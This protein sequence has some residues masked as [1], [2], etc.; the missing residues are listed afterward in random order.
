MQLRD[1]SPADFET[2]WKIDQEC[3]PPGIAYSRLELMHYLRRRG[4]FA[5][6]AEQDAG[7]NVR[8]AGFL[9]AECQGVRRRPAEVVRQVGHI[10]TLDVREGARRSGIGS[11]LMDEAERRLKALGCE[12]V[13]LETAVNN[14]PAISFY[15]RRGYSVLRA[16]P[17]YYEGKLD[18]LLMGKTMAQS[19][20]NQQQATSK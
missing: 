5:L 8:A 3:F 20:S 10:I 9:V 17:H 12:I 13:C 6:V 11:R 16:I 15:K 7:G 4:A 14:L 19:N 2:L 1:Y 18:A